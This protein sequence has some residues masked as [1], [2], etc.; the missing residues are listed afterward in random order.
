MVSETEETTPDTT[1]LDWNELRQ[2]S[3]LPGG[4]REQRVELWS[5]LNSLPHNRVSKAFRSKLL[6]ASVLPKEENHDE[7]DR[8]KADSEGHRDERQIRL[9]TDR[10]FVF[11][12]VCPCHSSFLVISTSNL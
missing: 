6:N 9:D 12:P 3:L 1:A 8:A 2:R 4:F 10:S 7:G 11:Y 5:V